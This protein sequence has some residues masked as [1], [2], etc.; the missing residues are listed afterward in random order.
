MLSPPQ[1]NAPGPGRNREA[2][3]TIFKLKIA[4]TS[5]YFGSDLVPPSRHKHERRSEAHID[6]LLDIVTAADIGV[7]VDL[8]R[9]LIPPVYPQIYGD[10]AFVEI[11][12][13]YLPRF[14]R[15]RPVCDL[16]WR[17]E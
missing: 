5:D 13:R 1:S 9:A 16:S 7:Q 4:P 14:A 6:A 3:Q 10:V 17:A 12:D 8:G 11:H 2:K 15:P